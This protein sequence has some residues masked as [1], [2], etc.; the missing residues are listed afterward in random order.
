MTVLTGGGCASIYTDG[1]Y[2]SVDL[3][4]VLQSAVTQSNLDCSDM[5]AI[6]KREGQ[7][8]VHRLETTRADPSRNLS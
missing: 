5:T 8:S 3:D 2:K 1:L 4:Y 7:E 6:S